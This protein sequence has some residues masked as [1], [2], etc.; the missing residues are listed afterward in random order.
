MIEMENVRK[1]YPLNGKL[2]QVLKG[3]NLYIT[4]GEFV[5][6]MGPSGSGKSTLAAILGCLA[7][8]SEGSYKLCGL[9][10]SSLSANKIAEMRSRSIGF[11][12]QDFN[13]LAGLS[14]LDNVA[15][16]LVYAGIPVRERR[17]R[18]LECLEALI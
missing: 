15:L 13:L 6:I 16:P 14:A 5:S 4:K 8:Q 17:R 7:R 18:S 11:V 10:I 1:T 2:V 9:E 3:I 12:F